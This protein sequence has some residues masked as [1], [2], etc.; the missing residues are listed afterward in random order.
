MTSFGDYRLSFATLR[1]VLLFLGYVLALVSLS[2]AVVCYH[3]AEQ[4][5]EAERMRHHD[6]LDILKSVQTNADIGVLRGSV[7]T[8][9]NQQAITSDNIII[10]FKRFATIFLSIS[11]GN[12]VLV[13]LFAKFKGSE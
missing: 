1:R 2:L 11:I 13:L 12:A 3:S 7:V 10:I 5:Q 8:L 6:V 4:E 9:L